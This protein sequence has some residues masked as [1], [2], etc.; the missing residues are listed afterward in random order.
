M[1]AQPSGWRRPDGAES[2][3]SS[4]TR[5]PRLRVRDSRVSLY[6]RSFPSAP[7]QEQDGKA[8]AV[9]RIL[10]FF[11]ELRR[12]QVYRVAATHTDDLQ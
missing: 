12:R 4:S 7:G 10:E 6:G 8:D 9:K 3:A 11:A 5:Q 2:R 1:D